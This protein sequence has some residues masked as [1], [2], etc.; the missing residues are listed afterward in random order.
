LHV[1]HRFEMSIWD[2]H[3]PLRFAQMGGTL[4]PEPGAWYYALLAISDDAEFL[5]QVWPQEAA[6]PYLTYRQQMGL[7]W[8]GGG[9]VLGA[10]ANRGQAVLDAVTELTFQ[11]IS[12]LSEANARFWE[13]L[14]AYEAGEL[15]DAAALFDEVLRL[16]PAQA[17][18]HFYAGL[19]HWALAQPDV[20]LAHLNQATTLDPGND[21]YW[22]QL[23]RLYAT[24]LGDQ[25]QALAA[26]ARALGLAPNE[27]RSYDVR[28]MI[29]RDMPGQ[30]EA[31]LADFDKA[32]TLAPTTPEMLRHRAET[33]NRLGRYAEALR[34]AEQCAHLQPGDGL[35]YLEQARSLAGLGDAAAASAA[36]RLFLDLPQQPGCEGCAPEA[37]DYIAAHPVATTP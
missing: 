21:E 17:P 2:R 25:P 4:T 23:A 9:W 30:V 26:V 35:C 33:L 31:A 29:L 15:T 8:A 32:V 3:T 19:A 11:S 1:S 20:A 34:D 5:A 13:G 18:Y 22:R 27:A 37:Q 14:G 6:A 36:Y 10:G 28:A 24:A 16:A 7:P 12:P